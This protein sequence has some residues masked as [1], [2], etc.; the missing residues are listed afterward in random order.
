MAE[1]LW[2]VQ[3]WGNSRDDTAPDW[4]GFYPTEDLARAA[5]KALRDAGLGDGLDEDINVHEIRG[6]SAP[7]QVIVWFQVSLLASAEHLARRIAAPGFAHRRV[8]FD[9]AP[10]SVPTEDLEVEEIRGGFMF[11]GLSAEKVE[12]AYRA[13]RDTMFPVRD[14][15]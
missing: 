10:G 9:P 13:R 15:G 4:E 7:P 3:F 11:K 1:A 14:A 12:A 8:S 6:S 2:H 5:E